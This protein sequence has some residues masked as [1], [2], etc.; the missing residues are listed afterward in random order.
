MNIG[1]QARIALFEV[2]AHYL[3]EED[4][5]KSKAIAIGCVLVIVSVAVCIGAATMNGSH[6]SD[7][8]G[9]N[10]PESPAIPDYTHDSKILVVYFSKTG[11]TER[12]AQEISDRLNSDIIEINP[13][14]SY[15]DSYSETIRIAEQEKN[16]DARPEI[17]PVDVDMTQYDIVLIG[18]PI[19]Y[20]APP[21]VVLTFLEGFDLTGKTVIN[22]ATSGSSPISETSPFIEN[23]IGDA[24]FIQGDRLSGGNAA[25]N[26]LERMG[27]IETN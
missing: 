24:S 23:S 10:T 18:Y 19:W 21:M 25:T 20:R 11:T 14:V 3:R 17:Q 27:F 6:D 22:F 7:D 16:D 2:P 26:F 4:V 9:P 12:Y 1:P 13:V 15:P 5:M 8:S